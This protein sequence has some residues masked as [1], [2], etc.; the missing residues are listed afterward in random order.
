MNERVRDASLEGD[1]D[2][3]KLP[4]SVVDTPFVNV[5]ERETTRE[6]VDE[7]VLVM[8]MVSD[9]RV[10]GVCVER[11][12]RLIELVSVR[13]AVLDRV[14]LSDKVAVAAAVRVKDPSNVND[15]EAVVD[16]ERE[17]DSEPV[18]VI[19]GVPRVA[20]G[21]FEMDL[22]RS[23]DDDAVAEALAVLVIG[24]LG[25]SEEEWAPVGVPEEDAD[26]DVVVLID[27]VGIGSTLRVD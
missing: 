7:R 19:G 10:D 2:W 3:H 24:E 26:S 20:D 18:R 14:R 16:L 23:Q 21:E 15:T 17:N 8:P 27:N 6:I 13:Y 22:V 1:A 12:D 25:V 4:D 9:A 11:P 5:T